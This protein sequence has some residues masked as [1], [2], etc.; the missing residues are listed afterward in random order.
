MQPYVAA[1][2]PSLRSLEDPPPSA[3]S[4]LPWAA[5][6]REHRLCRPAA[7][8]PHGP[9]RGRGEPARPYIVRGAAQQHDCLGLTLGDVSLETLQRQ[10]VP[11]TLFAHERAYG[12]WLAG[13]SLNCA[14]GR[15]RSLPRLP[16]EQYRAV[17]TQIKFVRKSGSPL[18]AR[19]VSRSGGNRLTNV[20]PSSGF[21]CSIRARS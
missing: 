6:R 19:R 17:D 5:A 11:R 4:S 3:P 12:K 10:D 8:D 14:S 1:W 18:A 15:E 2:D 9:L 20:C 16:Y 13:D 7:P 21:N